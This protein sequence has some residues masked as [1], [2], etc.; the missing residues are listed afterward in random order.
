MS[1]LDI[2]EF[3]SRKSQD[4]IFTG[5]SNSDLLEFV[6]RQLQDMPKVETI[7]SSPFL[8]LSIIRQY[9]AMQ[10]WEYVSNYAPS[11]LTLRFHDKDI[12]IKIKAFLL[13]ISTTIS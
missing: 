7:Y 13:I 12:S 2:Q 3:V 8:Q 5:L 10:V 1:D 6:T 11:L 9:V 4:D